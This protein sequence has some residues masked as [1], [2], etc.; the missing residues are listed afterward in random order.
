MA[1][2]AG[3]IGRKKATF[4]LARTPQVPGASHPFTLAAGS[5]RAVKLDG[6]FVVT[7]GMSHEQVRY[8]RDVCK[9]LLGE[10]VS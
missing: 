9:E 3:A 6:G 4:V 10:E 7:L 5:W 8:L 1:D 2:I